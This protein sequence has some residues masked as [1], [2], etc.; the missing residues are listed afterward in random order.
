MAPSNGSKS[1][2]PLWGS[3][4]SNSA[5]LEIWVTLEAEKSVREC[6]CDAQNL[7]QISSDFNSDCTASHLRSKTHEEKC[8]RSQSEIV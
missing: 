1:R 3:S 4:K 5:W 8:V 6:Q 2:G 7:D